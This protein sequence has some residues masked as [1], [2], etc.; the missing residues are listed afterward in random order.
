MRNIFI[1]YMPPGN[2]E[3]MVHYE[4][5]IRQKVDPEVIYSF[6]VPHLKRRLSSIFG[7]KRIATWGS[8]D[9]P[10]NRQKFDRMKEGDEVLIVEGETVRLLGRVAGKIVSPALSR[11][12][13]QNLRGESTDGW[14]L[15][16]FIANPREV[17]VS[18][19][20][21]R[22]LLGYSAEFRLRGFTAVAEEKLEA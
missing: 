6:A 2:M 21:V 15:V 20:V 7:Q 11:Q 1:L 3:A 12:L 19:Q 16:Y 9:S 14:D 18:F 13:W 4:D 17:G 22:E 10:Q 8:R 5:T